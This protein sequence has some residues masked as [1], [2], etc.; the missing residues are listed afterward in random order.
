LEVRNWNS[1]WNISSLGIA[2]KQVTMS[3][4]ERYPAA[5]TF[6]R[7]KLVLM[8]LTRWWLVDRSSFTNAGN[9]T[10]FKK[11]SDPSDDAMTRGRFT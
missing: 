1:N 7:R 8:L 6:R 4:G 2:E 9:A 11:S 10:L 3:S 5:G